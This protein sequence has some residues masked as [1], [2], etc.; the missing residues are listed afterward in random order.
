MSESSTYYL[1]SKIYCLGTYLDSS[2]SGTARVMTWIQKSPEY[3]LEY[4]SKVPELVS[5]L[6]CDLEKSKQANLPKTPS[7]EPARGGRG[8]I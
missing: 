2:K 7:G 1:D 5:I 6:T 3:T 8:L 4:F